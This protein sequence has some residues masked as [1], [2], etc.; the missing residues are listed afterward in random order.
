[1]SRSRIQGQFTKQASS[2]GPQGVGNDDNVVLY[3]PAGTTLLAWWD[4]RTLAAGAVSSWVDRKNSISAAQA[5]GAK[6]PI[7][8]TLATIPVVTFN[9]TTHALVSGN[10][11]FADNQSV[12]V[13]MVFT[14]AAV[15]PAGA[16]SIICES[17]TAGYTATYGIFALYDSTGGAT[18]GIATYVNSPGGTNYRISTYGY[19]NM[20]CYACVNDKSV[21]DRTELMLY[22]NGSEFPTTGSSFADNTDGFSTDVL[23]IGSRNNG[24]G[25]PWKGSI[26]QIAVYTGASAM[27]VAN[28]LAIDRALRNITKIA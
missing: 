8:G 16:Q 1:M 28:F 25:A 17:G 22:I 15:Q 7:A 26:A 5:T 2:W 18:G 27:P 21:S 12:T 10:L 20:V 3:P 9:G 4:A 14:Q 19:T 6:Q 13:F 11:A 24:A 23:N